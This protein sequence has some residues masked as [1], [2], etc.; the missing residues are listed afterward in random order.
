VVLPAPIN[1]KLKELFP[2]IKNYPL[3]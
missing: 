2:N 1:T 3:F